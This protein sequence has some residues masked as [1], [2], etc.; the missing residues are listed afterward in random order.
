MPTENTK[1]TNSAKF[2]KRSKEKFGDKFDYAKVEYVT[3]EVPILLICK[4][5]QHE[6]FI[7]PK[8]HYRSNEGGCGY[9][10]GQRGP[11]VS[12]E[13]FIAKAREYH[14]DKYGYDKVVFKGTIHAVTIVCPLHGDFEQIAADHYRSG[15]PT[16]KHLNHRLTQDE[17]VN[18][19]TE[20]HGG[21]YIYDKT[22]YNG[23][24][25]KII[26]TC[27]AHGDFEQSAHDHISGRGCPKCKAK[28]YGWEGM[29]LYMFQEKSKGLVKVGITKKTLD[30]RVKELNWQSG[31]NFE[32]LCSYYYGDGGDAKCIEMDLLKWMSEHFEPIK[33][34]F[35]GYSEVFRTTNTTL[36]LNKLREF[37]CK[38]F[39]DVC[40]HSPTH[41][42]SQQVC[43]NLT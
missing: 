16:C 30:W 7:V 23:Y 40:K 27:P 1:K 10:N 19:V 24:E 32:V 25:R 33:E 6:F 3:K 11:R 34:R 41:D 13:H 28:L 9:C 39:S 22:V 36:I 29:H 26:I 12:K 31:Y 2:V 15:C 35:Y 42:A 38:H 21:R 18:R 17:F 5:H 4:E 43:E 8:N 14:G 37:T 20:I